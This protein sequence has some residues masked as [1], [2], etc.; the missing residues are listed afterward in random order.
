MYASG[1][2]HP[3]VLHP[4]SVCEGKRHAPPERNRNATPERSLVKLERFHMNHHK[5]HQNYSASHVI[6]CLFKVRESGKRSLS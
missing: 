1:I 2:A 3:Q 6:G 5:H 4:E